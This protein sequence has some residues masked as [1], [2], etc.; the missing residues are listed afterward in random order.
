MNALERSFPTVRLP[1]LELGLFPTPVEE[2]GFTN[3]GSSLW[4]KREDLSG[5]IYG[6]NKVR[7]L[8]YLLQ[9]PAARGQ[10]VLSYGAQGSNHLLATA[11]YGRQQGLA[12]HA[13]IAPQPSTA[14]VD[15][16][17]A[18]LLPRLDERLLVRSRALIPLGA[19]RLLARLRKRGLPAPLTIAAGGSNAIGSIG[20]VAGGLEIAEQVAR[21]ELPEPD[22]IWVALGSMGNAAGLLVG[23]RLAGLRSALMGVRVVELPLTTRTATLAIAHRTLAVLRHHG[24]QPPKGMRLRGLHVVNDFLGPGYGHD[25][26]E[27]LRAMQ[28]GESEMGLKLEGT[29][30]A[31]ALAGCLARLEAGAAGRHVLFMNT[32]NSRPLAEL[33]PAA[34][35]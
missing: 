27:A 35:D 16:N 5:A 8:E 21:G 23:L 33:P 14:H 34:G 31:K 9:A 4:V 13:V 7:K 26:P 17:E 19:L 11:V 2:T 12:V 15:A 10:A 29:Y 24:L 1:R 30:T 32:V 6:G 28:I 22:Q 18:A 20:W 25:T 3:Q